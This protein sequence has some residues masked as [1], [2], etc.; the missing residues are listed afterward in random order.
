MGYEPEPLP[1]YNDL[2]NRSY[3]IMLNYTDSPSTPQIHLPRPDPNIS[4]SGFSPASA[5]PWR[6]VH[7]WGGIPPVPLCLTV[8]S[9]CTPVWGIIPLL[10]VP[11]PLGDIPTPCPPHHVNQP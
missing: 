1:S 11:P 4:S 10:I 2:R 3:S 7:K 6:R 5:L 9:E 8:V